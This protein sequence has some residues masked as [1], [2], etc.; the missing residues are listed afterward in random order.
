MQVLLRGSELG[1]SWAKTLQARQE[2]AAALKKKDEER[3]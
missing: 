2:M 3:K 1:S